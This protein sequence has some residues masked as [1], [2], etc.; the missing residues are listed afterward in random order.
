MS[1][2]E[3][4]YRT[5][6]YIALCAG[7]GTVGIGFLAV[8][9][10]TALPTAAM[11]PATGSSL[12]F[13]SPSGLA[14]NGGDLWVS[15]LDGNSV[16][17]I[18]P[19]SG[20]LIDTFDDSSYQFN[21]PTAI[22]S[23]GADLFVANAGGSVTELQASN[24]ALV[25]VISGSQFDFADPVAIDAVG[26]T[27]I[28]LSAGEPNAATPVPASITEID[29]ATGDLVLTNSKSNL[30]LDDPTAL[31]VL[32]GDIFVADEGNNSV[33]EA[34]VAT[35]K[36]VRVITNPGLGAPDGI[37]SGDGNVWAVDSGPS[38]VTEIDAATGAVINTFDDNNGSY[39]FASPSVAIEPK[40]AVFIASPFGSS[41]MITKVGKGGAAKW[42]MCNTNGPYYFSLPSAFAVS[43]KDLWVASSSGANN[44]NSDAATG[45]LTEMLT[46][47]GAL[48]KTLPQS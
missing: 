7:F 35:D 8:P 37:A 25:R 31:T 41:P 32:N 47:T 13:D 1:R 22:T 36:L 16:T 42:Y 39:G 20:A 44:P 24:G 27:I 11:A 48:V 33:T 9:T 19:T 34:S 4:R 26:D 15:N 46:S 2:F 12:E 28:V 18:N 6:L 29:A 43:G 40:G 21:Q 10:A 3:H 5:P 14:F 17:E 30:A 45:S 38:G 23:S